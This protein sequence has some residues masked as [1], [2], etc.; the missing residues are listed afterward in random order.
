MRV[1]RR[2]FDRV[3]A[4]IALAALFA[5]QLAPF[6]DHH[7]LER[8]PD[9]G[10]VLLVPHSHARALT[11]PHREWQGPRTRPVT[12]VIVLPDRDA[13][14]TPG[15]VDTGVVMSGRAIALGAPSD[16]SPAPN[17][18]HVERPADPYTE[19]PDPPPRA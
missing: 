14:T 15:A 18:A 6:F 5:P 10:H 19:P 13:Q 8:L 7:A 1:W 12:A 17:A 11:L 2:S 3:C 4:L 9:H 16:A